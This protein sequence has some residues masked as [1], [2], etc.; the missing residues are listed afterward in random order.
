MVQVLATLL[1]TWLP[2][3]TPGRQTA[4]AQGPSF[5]VPVTHARELNGVP[6]SWL[7]SSPDKAAVAIWRV[8]SKW[9]LSVPSLV[10]S[11]KFC[12]WEFYGPSYK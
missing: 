4:A 9:K 11:N 2:A 10:L 1:L 8:N 6:G 5:G 7:L 3:D 12:I